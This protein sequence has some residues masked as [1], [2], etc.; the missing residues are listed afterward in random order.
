MARTAPPARTRR[1]LELILAA[2]VL[3]AGVAL[4]VVAILALEHPKGRTA[5]SLAAA[6][7]SSSSSSSE[8]AP[9]GS[10]EGGQPAV[11]VLNDTSNS[12]LAENGG[13]T[14]ELGGLDG[15]ANRDVRRRHSLDHG[16]LRPAAEQAA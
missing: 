9:S 6:A 10:T 7:T 11:V 5:Q 15:V 4:A 12:A 16:L 13:R 2:V 3:S 14:L 8:A 1:T